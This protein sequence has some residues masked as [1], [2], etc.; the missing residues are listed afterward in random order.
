MLLILVQISSLF[1]DQVGMD[2]DARVLI[3]WPTL[4]AL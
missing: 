4:H 3:G 2:G 1:T